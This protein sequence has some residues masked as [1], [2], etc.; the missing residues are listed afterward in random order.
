MYKSP[1]D[2]IYTQLESQL[3]DEIMRAVQSVHV[4]V[5]K[6]ELLKA[7]QED[8]RQYEKGYLDGKADATPKWIPVTERLPSDRGDVLVVAW[9]HEKWQTMVGWYGGISGRWHIITIKGD[10]P[11]DHVTHWM[12]L[13][14]PPKGE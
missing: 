12:P 13:P 3:E 14:E 5:D 7:L 8:R 1:I 9:W 6:D 4:N 2:I 11:C 10:F